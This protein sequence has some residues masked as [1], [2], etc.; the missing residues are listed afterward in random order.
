VPK[1]L[2]VS[3]EHRYIPDTDNTVCHEQRESESESERR[4]RA[5]T[6]NEEDSILYCTVSVRCEVTFLVINITTNNLV[7]TDA[8]SN[9]RQNAKPEMQKRSLNVRIC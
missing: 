1:E 5:P 4:D 9:C 7:M 2:H 3:A 8:F 6:R